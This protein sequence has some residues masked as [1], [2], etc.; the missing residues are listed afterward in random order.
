M[1]VPTRKGERV[2]TQLRGESS[3]ECARRMGWHVGTRLVG[4]EGYGAT[5]IRITAIGESQVLAVS[6]SHCGEYVNWRE[7]S[8]TF[9]CRDWKPADTTTE[10]NTK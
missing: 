8:W 4:D 7:S 5:V 9:S 3:A 1:N 2:S 6:K 10:G